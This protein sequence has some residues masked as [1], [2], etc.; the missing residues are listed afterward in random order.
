MESEARVWLDGKIVRYSESRVP[1]LTHSLQYG[2]GIFEGIR[3]YDTSESASIFR[4]RE[5]VLRFLR[6]MKIYSM[7]IP[8]TADD[9]EKGIR[10]IISLNEYRNAYIRPFAFYNDDRIGLSTVGKKVSV[11]IG[12]VPF[13]SY[14]SA[15]EMKGLKCKVSSWH[16]PSSAVLPIEAKASGNYLNSIIANRE[17]VS[18]GYD[19]AILTSTAG[20]ITEGPGENIFLVSGNRLITPSVESDI[21]VG[22]TRDTV[23]KLAADMGVEVIER[24]VHREELYNA[25]ELFFAGTAAEISP[26]VEVDGIIVS[27]GSTGKITGKIAKLYSD[28]VTGKVGKYE[29]WLTR[30]T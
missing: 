10:D 29:T 7:S 4:L 12:A 28:T 18:M 26:I 5:H 17:A 24:F 15:K 14:Y 6:S 20:Y 1:V 11:F 13:K 27:E 25:D 22:I 30:I 21:L 3:S 2:S 19:E 23:M 8:F 9:I 16:R